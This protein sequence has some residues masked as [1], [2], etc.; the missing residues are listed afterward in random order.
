[1]GFPITDFQ[2]PVTTP[3]RLL[4]DHW[5][6][7]ISALG[8]EIG[9]L[10]SE[11]MFLWE[12][13]YSFIIPANRYCAS[14]FQLG[15]A[16]LDTCL[17]SS[18]SGRERSMEAARATRALLIKSLRCISES[19]PLTSLVVIHDVLEPTLRRICMRLETV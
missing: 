12:I 8:V 13:L 3:A 5:A 17:E 14:F 15:V 19:D 9:D 10:V 18:R 7:K 4:A 6:A 11:A 2:H 16:L 1:M